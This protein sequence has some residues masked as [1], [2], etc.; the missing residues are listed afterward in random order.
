[1]S[2]CGCKVLKLNQ[3][4]EELLADWEWDPCW[5]GGTN[6]VTLKLQNPPWLEL[7]KKSSHL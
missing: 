3:T 1:M 4:V 7:N 2:L 6:A 5:S